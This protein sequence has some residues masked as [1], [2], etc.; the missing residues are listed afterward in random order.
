MV[1]GAHG[2][3]EEEPTPPRHRRPVHRLVPEAVEARPE[4]AAEDGAEDDE[5]HQQ[6]AAAAEGARARAAHLVRAEVVP[7]GK[8][9][10]PR[11]APRV[12]LPQRGLRD[13]LDGADDAARV[14]AS[15]EGGPHLL[16]HDP[17][18]HRVRDP[19]L[20]PVPHLDA[21]LPVVDEDGDQHAVVLPPEAGLPRLGDAEA[22]VLDAL[23]V[24]AGQDAD[25]D[26]LALLVELHQPALDL[27][28]LGAVEDAGAVVEEARGRGRDGEG[29]RQRGRQRREEGDRSSSLH[30]KRT[31]G[32]S[33]APCVAVK[34]GFSLNPSIPDMIR[35]GK[36]F[37][38][39]LY[40]PTAS[41]NRR[42]STEIRFSVPASSAWRPSK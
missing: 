39:T 4:D 2:V 31:L 42:R 11:V 28:P 37:T 16:H 14:V 38:A 23:A 24:Q 40:S 12:A 41:L 30:Q 29:Q 34:Y 1:A 7:A 17:P 3:A 35:V 13:G 26:L 20:Q 15:T 8:R 22:G 21:H 32:A 27:L 18:R 25:A 36:L 9:I 33:D 19:A 6:E 10:R 5:R